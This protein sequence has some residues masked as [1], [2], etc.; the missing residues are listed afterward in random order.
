MSVQSW[1]AQDHQTYSTNKVQ[2]PMPTDM[3][4]TTSL[5]ITL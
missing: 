1:P 2:K 5:L 4:Q 3:Q